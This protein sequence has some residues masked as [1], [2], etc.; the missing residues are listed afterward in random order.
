[1]VDR[2]RRVPHWRRTKL[3]LFSSLLAPLALL[4]LAFMFRG[5]LLEQS[6]LGIP[7]PLLLLVHG[8]ALSSV[9]LVARFV[10]NQAAVDRI[11]GTHDTRA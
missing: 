3:T 2:S 6:W 10:R 4:G 7:V 5:D 11:H 8:A 9:L 1:M